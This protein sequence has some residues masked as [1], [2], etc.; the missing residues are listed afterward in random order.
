MLVVSLSVEHMED[1][2]YHGCQ[3]PGA[4][5]YL[6]TGSSSMAV[7]DLN[8]QSRRR[9]PCRLQLVK[10]LEGSNLLCLATA[11]VFLFSAYRRQ[12]TGDLGF[13]P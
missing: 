1:A 12:Y 8:E 5:S 3:S 10:P 6:S 13:V 7:A 4:D 2:A 9:V 11:S